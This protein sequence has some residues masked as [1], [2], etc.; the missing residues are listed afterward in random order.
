MRLAYRLAPLAP[1]VLL[2]AAQAAAERLR[3]GHRDLQV[4]L[5]APPS[6]PVSRNASF[7]WNSTV[8]G[9]VNIA[10]VISSDG[11][12]VF[13]AGETSLFALRTKDGGQIWS[14]QLGGAIT[15][16]TPTTLNGSTLYVSA[17]NGALYAVAATAGTVSWTYLTG[18]R[19]QSPAAVS[20]DRKTVYVSSYDGKLYALDAKTGDRL[21]AA[22]TGP[23]NVAVSALV[24]PGG[25]RVFVMNTAG[26]AYAFNAA[27][28]SSAW[29]AD[30][31]QF[32]FS[33]PPPALA[34]D[35][36]LMYVPYERGVKALRADN[37]STV[38]RATPPAASYAIS[39]ALTVDPGNKNLFLLGTDGVINALDT[40][41][42]TLTWAYN[43]TDNAVKNAWGLAPDFKRQML[44]F[45]NGDNEIW[46]IKA[47]G[48][49]Q[50][51]RMTGFELIIGISLGITAPAISTEGRQQYLYVGSGRSRPSKEGYVYKVHAL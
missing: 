21:W 23:Y 46:G 34:P 17:L 49:S 27:D 24:N 30:T 45:V 29:R 44:Y 12:M 35:G 39:A 19:I 42:G 40:R 41:D 32:M 26:T 11:S 43:N 37:G 10:P 5:P 3:G 36:S 47:M 7:V 33:S 1:L 16:M 2:L 20:P 51:Q 22:S 18:D 6:Q 15:G 50:L 14:T 13:V 38:W 28:G 8:D 4:S 31:D 25:S 9:L 48:T